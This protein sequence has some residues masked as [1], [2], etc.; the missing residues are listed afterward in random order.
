MEM[1]DEMANLCGPGYDRMTREELIRECENK[2]RV[3][4]YLNEQADKAPVAE[5]AAWRSIETAPH[6]D[7]PVLLLVPTLYGKWNKSIQVTGRWEDRPNGGGFW[8]IFNADEAI[9]RVEATHWMP[10]L[11]SPSMN[12]GEGRK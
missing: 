5:V 7:E 8:T 3:I 10:R 4:N 6:D 11:P 1:G 12:L 2:Q 9:Q